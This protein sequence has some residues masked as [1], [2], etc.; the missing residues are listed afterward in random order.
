MPPATEIDA[1]PTSTSD[2]GLSLQSTKER[3]K[4]SEE[5][6]WFATCHLS[7]T[8]SDDCRADAFTEMAE[9]HKIMQLLIAEFEEPFGLSI[10]IIFHSC[11]PQH[12]ISECNGDRGAVI[13]ESK[14]IGNRLIFCFVKCLE[15]RSGAAFETF[16]P[17]FKP[18]APSHFKALAG[19]ADRCDTFQ[20]V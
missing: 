2:G 11:R 17:A 8:A 1:S 14:P 13:P 20:L 18:F 3:T 12:G 9:A 6:A 16:G 5:P 7:Q 10:T 4:L 19:R 15:E